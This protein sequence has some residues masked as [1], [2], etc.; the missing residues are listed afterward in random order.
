MDKSKILTCELFE[1]QKYFE[2]QVKQSDPEK[3]CSLWLYQE[4]ISIQRHP[5]FSELITHK[6]DF[7]L[8]T[9]DV[10]N[11]LNIHNKA[12][13]NLSYYLLLLLSFISYPQF[14][15]LTSKCFLQ[16]KFFLSGLFPLEDSWSNDLEVRNNLTT[17]SKLHKQIFEQNEAIEAFF[18]FLNKFCYS[19]LKLSSIESGNYIKINLSLQLMAFR[20]IHQI[21]D[22]EHAR[23]A[24]YFVSGVN[25]DDVSIDLFFS[26]IEGINLEDI[27]FIDEPLNLPK[28][29]IQIK[30]GDNV[31]FDSIKDPENTVL[32]INNLEAENALN[33]ITD[34]KLD[35]EIGRVG[36][37]VVIKTRGCVV[38]D[39]MYGD[40]IQ[41]EN[42]SVYTAKNTSIYAGE[43]IEIMNELKFLRNLKAYKIKIGDIKNKLRLPIEYA[44]QRDHNIPIIEAV[45]IEICAR[46]KGNL[47]ILCSRESFENV[48]E[49]NR[50]SKILLSQ[51]YQMKQKFQEVFAQKEQHLDK[52]LRLKYFSNKSRYLLF[53]E[54]FRCLK[55]KKINPILL[56]SML[57][58][59]GLASYSLLKRLEFCQQLNQLFEKIQPGKQYDLQRE[60]NSLLRLADYSQGKSMEQRVN[61]LLTLFLSKMLNAIRLVERI[62]FTTFLEYL[63]FSIEN[64]QIS[65][66]KSKLK[67][68]KERKKT[69]E[70][71]EVHID[72][73]LTPDASIDF[74]YRQANGEF[75]SQDLLDTDI[76]HVIKNDSGAEW[77]SK[78][79]KINIIDGIVNI[80]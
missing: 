7:E 54:L 14:I 56:K 80:S 17:I 46:L 28:K 58:K 77:E 79:L 10:S 23:S 37:G 65:D 16:E 38:C 8:D 6:F 1:I 35:L 13:Y 52:S 61:T 55:N 9:L 22:G 41:G 70:Q 72:C 27:Q 78:V 43:S 64:S 71:I 62:D 33:T 53:F 69:L 49:I 25:F 26:E 75:V 51:E 66:L 5:K 63:S 47:R 18:H 76:I 15:L 60:I 74:V 21:D 36:D 67:E 48:Q 44:F 4:I 3:L 32:K 19:H 42:V 31:D 50:Q 59:S 11:N 45:K 40:S 2:S 39:S 12:Q 34:Q 24:F 57:S 30:D 68:L 20:L 73:Q 29:V